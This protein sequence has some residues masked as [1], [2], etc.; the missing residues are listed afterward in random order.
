[1]HVL[2]IVVVKELQGIDG[3]QKWIELDSRKERSV[4]FHCDLSGGFCE[5]EEG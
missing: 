3:K 1:M 2:D 5:D 4:F